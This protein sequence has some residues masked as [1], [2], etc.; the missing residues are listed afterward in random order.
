MAG[1]YIHIP[2]CKQACNYCNFYFSTSL[3]FK[4]AFLDAIEKEISLQKNYLTGEKIESV[5][6]G[7]G[8]PSILNSKELE[9]I[10]R[11][12]QN[13]FDVTANAELTLEATP[14]D[15]S[16]SKLADLKALG[17]NRLSIGTQSFHQE[18][19]NFMQRAH[20]AKEAINCIKDASKK[21]FQNLSIDLIYGAPTQTINSFK[22]NLSM[23][24]ELDVN[25]LSSYAL[26][27]EENTPLYHQ[28]RKGKVQNVDEDLA[29]IHFEILQEWAYKHSWNHYEISNLCREDNYSKH[30]TAYWQRKKYLGLGPGAHSFNGPMRHWNIS[31]LKKYT[32]SLATN[33]LLFESETL[34]QEDIFN[35]IVMTGLRT[36]WGVHKASLQ[37]TFP[38]FYP[39]FEKQIGLINSSWIKNSVENL[40]LSDQGRFYADG[41]AASLFVEKTV[42]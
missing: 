38:N 25:H 33:T 14:D 27:V 31:N 36:S 29:A 17:I 16:P 11:H 4:A 37:K 40:S 41:I 32:D 1:I 35:E 30:N 42:D 28:I 23:L 7:G 39:N 13:N 20:N 9:N 3:N 24:K 18:D 12:I 6:F 8:T 22:Q 21:G 5:Y 2:F 26:T 15:L 10:L 19:L 34:S